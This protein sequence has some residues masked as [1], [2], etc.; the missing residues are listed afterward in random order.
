MARWAMVAVVLLAV[1]GVAAFPADGNDRTVQ[2]AG[3]AIGYVNSD[4]ILRQTPGF[5]AAD[6]TLRAELQTYEAEINQLRQELDSAAAA[7]DQSS[8]LLSPTA[9][10]EKLA[11][12]QAMQQRGQTRQQE[13]QTRASQ[14]EQELVAPLQQRIQ[15]VIDGIRA[16]RNLAVIFDVAS[17]TTSIVSADPALNLTQLVVQ[18]VQSSGSP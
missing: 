15:T 12:L 16:E 6:S 17:P 2:G 1:V 7:F 18:R 8:V 4:I 5:A 9:R 3:A 14:R 10:D 11:E 13:L